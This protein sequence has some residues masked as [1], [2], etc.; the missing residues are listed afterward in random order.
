VIEAILLLQPPTFAAAAFFA[1][2]LTAL[3]AAFLAVA[4]VDL[5]TLV[6]LRFGE[7]ALRLF[8]YHHHFPL[9]L[10]FLLA[11]TR[12]TTTF[13]SA[14]TTAPAFHMCL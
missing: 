10:S 2:S 9:P 11:P 7:F 1:V 4:L 5:S 12:A 8:A 14:A 3:V 6:H 13:T